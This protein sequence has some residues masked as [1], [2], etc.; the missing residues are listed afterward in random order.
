MFCRFGF[1]FLNNYPGRT[2]RRDYG[3]RFYLY[4][5][6]INTECGVGLQL[7]FFV[8]QQEGE[9]G[10][11]GADT[12]GIGGC[13][14][15]KCFRNT[16]A[17]QNAIFALLEGVHKHQGISPSSVHKYLLPSELH[18]PIR[19]HTAVQSHTSYMYIMYRHTVG[20]YL[21][22]DIHIM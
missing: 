3:T 1:F 9:Q 13:V 4:D 11:G 6:E 12:T 22:T 21:Y 14:S 10:W 16:W 18:R 17:S 19:V 5:K 2:S 15:S 20:T 8:Q 7:A